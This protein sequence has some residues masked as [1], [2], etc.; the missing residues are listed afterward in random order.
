V[1]NLSL[2][3]LSNLTD[4]AYGLAAVNAT[5]GQAL[6]LRG[7]GGQYGA[8]TNGGFA[9]DIPLISVSGADVFLTGTAYG[10]TAVFGGLSVS[11]TGGRGQYFARYDTSGNAQVATTYGSTTTMPWASAANA[12]GVYISGDFDDYSRFGNAL[13]AAPVYAQSYLGS[14]YFT[15]P[16]VAK[17]DRNGNSLWARNGVSSLLANFRG[18]ATTSDGVWASG[19]VQVP[20]T[21]FPAQF[22]TNTVY[23][24]GYLYYYGTGVT[25]FFTQGGLLAKISE[26]AA[27]SPLTLLH[28]Q[29]VGS[30]FQFQ[31]LSQAGFTHS[32]LYRTN[33]VTG[34]WQ[35]NSSIGGDGT[36]K[37]IS[38]PFSVFGPSK[39][40]FVRVATQ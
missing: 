24:D 4:R 37:T 17:F 33:L 29:A 12:S 30:N 23:S 39:Q 36:L 10:F 6:W 16:F 40:G 28:P 13:I 14:Y 8:K 15:Q 22:G 32:V 20:S 19:I 2:G 1:T 27:A 9:D 26:A 34:A 3:G 21:V 18:I 31:F 7:A 38:I 35:T 25:F 5:N 11:L